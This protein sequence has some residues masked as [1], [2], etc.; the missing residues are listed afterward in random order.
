[1]KS[2]KIAKLLILAMAAILSLALVACDSDD[3]DTEIPSG[4]STESFE[5]TDTQP[6]ESENT[7]SDTVE[8]SAQSDT[9]DSSTENI[10]DSSDTESSEAPKF[11][12]FE[13]DMF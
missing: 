12:Y 11:S 2:T 7:D 6:D 13:E 4:S 5:E 8:S 9:T 3:V 10:E 1:M